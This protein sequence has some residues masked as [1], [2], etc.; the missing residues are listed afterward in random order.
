MTPLQDNLRA[1]ALMVAGVGTFCVGD[2]L[3]KDVTARLPIGEIMLLRGVFTVALLLALLPWLGQRVGIPDRFAVLRGVAEVGVMYAFMAAL[4]V[5]PLA[6]AYTLY[7]ASPIMLTATGALLLGE[8]VGPRRW[9]AVL[10]GFSGIL[11]AMGGPSAWQAATAL[12]LLAAALSVGRDL[13]TRRVAPAVGSGTVAVFSGFA[14]GAA[15]L[16]T[17]P[18]GWVVPTPADLLACFG[19]ATGAGAGYVLF[20]AAMRQGD[21]SFVAP[22]R[23]AAVPVALALDLILWQRAPEAHVLLGATIIIASGNFII[24]R[25]RALARHA[26]AEPLAAAA[27]ASPPTPDPRR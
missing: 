27:V 16:I 13:A 14:T 24:L 12:P 15:G 1:A 26:D 17:L 10:V 19:A 3:I 7:F 20:I 23:Y 25:E 9:L 5:L 11:I 18:L 8:R 6:D 21:L 4:I 2:A 22:F